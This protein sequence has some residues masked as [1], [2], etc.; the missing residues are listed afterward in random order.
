MRELR[1]EVERVRVCACVRMGR[2]KIGES[3]RKK[4]RED[5]NVLDDALHESRG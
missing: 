5:E 3:D 1:V 2:R 4:R